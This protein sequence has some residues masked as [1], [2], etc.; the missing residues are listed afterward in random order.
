MIKQ[1]KDLKVYIFAVIV[2]LCSVMVMIG[3][4]W[5]IPILTSF[6]PNAPAM[7]FTTAVCFVCSALIVILIAQSFAY[8][9][10]IALA[11]LPAPCL[12]IALMM[13]SIIISVVIG[14]KTGIEN[15]FVVE[16][17]NAILTVYPGRPSL[18]AVVCFVLILLTG[19]AVMFKPTWIRTYIRISGVMIFIFGAIGLCGYLFNVPVMYYSVSE[20]S[21]AMAIH[22]ALLFVIIGIAL[23]LLGEDQQ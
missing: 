5:H 14:I 3:W 6:L 19:L 16:D 17:I 21:T 20:I 23:M 9:H 12:I 4:I 1:K 13:A 2:L 7:K 15:M 11:C 8:K 18:G 22:T 10:N